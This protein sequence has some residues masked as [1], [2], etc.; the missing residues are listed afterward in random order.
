V[1]YSFHVQG[2]YI[3]VT[4]I[5]EHFFCNSSICFL[6]YQY[7]L[8]YWFVAVVG[9][10]LGALHLLGRRCISW[11]TLWTLQLNFYVQ[12]FDI[13]KVFNLFPLWRLR[14]ISNWRVFNGHMKNTKLHIIN[15]A[16]PRNAYF[17]STLIMRLTSASLNVDCFLYGEDV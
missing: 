17:M 4:F 2:F 13:W 11:P 6:I 14:T 9:F 5:T 10:E 1:F 8:F 7:L 3:F 16:L 15:G 12:F